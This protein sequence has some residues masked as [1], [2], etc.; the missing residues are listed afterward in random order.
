MK[1]L[2]TS[3]FAVVFVMS[4]AF[5][6]AVADE[7]ANNIL[8]ESTAQAD[9]LDTEVSCAAFDCPISTERVFEACVQVDDCSALTDAE[10]KR[11]I[12]GFFDRVC[13]KLKACCAANGCDEFQC[14]LVDYK[15][16]CRDKTTFCV[17]IKVAWRCG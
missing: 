1:G 10:I 6:N 15:F 14:R 3:L 8:P 16:G 4:F 9:V 13:A 5:T 2:L 11:M 7:N 12:D 17:K